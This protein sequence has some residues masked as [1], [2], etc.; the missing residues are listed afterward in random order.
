MTLMVCLDDRNGLLFN[1]RRQSRDKALIEDALAFVKDERITTDSY[2]AQ[3]FPED[4]VDVSEE[5]FSGSVCFA[6]RGDFLAFRSSVNQLVVYRWNRNYPADTYFPL[7][8]YIGSMKMVETS[9]FPG[10]SHDKITR[11]V[12]RR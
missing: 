6:E 10:N 2:T 8:E 12:Y 11:E 7:D 4:A 3:L 1:K 9:E 5:P